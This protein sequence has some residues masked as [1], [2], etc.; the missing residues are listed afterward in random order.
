MKIKFYKYQ[1]T[2]N[3]FILIENLDEKIDEKKKSYI[4]KKLCDRHFGVGADGLLFVEKSKIADVKMRIFNS[5]GSEAEMCGNGIRCFA[6]HVYD[7]NIVR[8]KIIKIE[9]LAGVK[10]VE[11]FTDKKDRVNYVKVDMGKPHFER[12]KIPAEGKGVLIKE[13]IKI[14]GGEFEISALNTG[15]PHV[16]IFVDNID[17]IDVEKIGRKIRFHKIFPKGTNVNFIQKIGDKKYRIRTYERGVEKETLACGTGATACGVLINYLGLDNGE[18]EITTKGGKIYIEP[19]VK[20]GVFE[21]AYMKGE[22]GFVFSGEIEVE[23]KIED[24]N[25]ESL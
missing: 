22:V 21:K 8:R 4:A 23:D 17:D 25:E 1:A 10:V 16:V 11:V 7:F 3:D 24:K 5:D 19:I 2:G 12:E 18:I 15:V 6:K 13:K 20:D 9:T 14:N